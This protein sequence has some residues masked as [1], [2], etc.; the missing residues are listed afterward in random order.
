MANLTSSVRRRYTLKNSPLRPIRH[1]Q[2]RLPESQGL[3]N[4]KHRGGQPSSG[5]Y[6]QRPPRPAPGPSG[7]GTSMA[8]NQAD[9]A[10]ADTTRINNNKA[11][12]QIPA[13]LLSAL[14]AMRL[15]DGAPRG[16]H[17]DLVGTAA[18]HGPPRDSDDQVHLAN[19]LAQHYARATGS[20]QHDHP[21]SY[22]E[23]LLGP[24]EAKTK[25]SD[26]QR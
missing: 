5:P 4:D 19:A 26:H 15:G 11:M 20:G 1:S 14:N 24:T 9:E 18:S 12:L 22:E 25:A 8:G 10:V 2:P 6:P 21:P 13:T 7:L 17:P 23:I 3:S 16:I